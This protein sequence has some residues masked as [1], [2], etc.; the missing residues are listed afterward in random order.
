MSVILSS[1]KIFRKFNKTEYTSGFEIFAASVKNDQ[2]VYVS[3]GQPNLIFCK[4]GIGAFP[5]VVNHDLNFQTAPMDFQSPLPSQLLGIGQHPPLNIGN[6]K[7]EPGDFCIAVSRSYVPP[8]L[9]AADVNSLDLSS[10]SQ[11]LANENP[12]VPFWLGIL[13]FE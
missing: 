2:F 6:Q 12:D 5:L 7:V 4:K 10:V 11:I 8:E 1:E 13:R 3:C 9:F